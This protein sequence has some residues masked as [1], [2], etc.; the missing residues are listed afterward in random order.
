MIAAIKALT[1][2]SIENLRI[3]TPS[4]ERAVWRWRPENSSS[5]LCPPTPTDAHPIS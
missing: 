4:L 1:A 3:A 5:E 2:T